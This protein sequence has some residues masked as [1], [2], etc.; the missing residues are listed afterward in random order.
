MKSDCC[1]CLPNL[2]PF[3]LCLICCLSSVSSNSG[4]CEVCP[5]P[6]TDC[7]CRHCLEDPDVYLFSDE[8]EDDEFTSSEEDEEML[9][10]LSDDTESDDE[11]EEGSEEF[12]DIDVVFAQDPVYRGELS[13]YPEL[14][15]PSKPDHIKEQF[16]T[17]E[18]RASY[19]DEVRDRRRECPV[20]TEKLGRFR[21]HERCVLSCGHIFCFDCINALIEVALHDEIDWFRCPMCRM[22]FRIDTVEEE[23]STKSESGEV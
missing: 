3:L 16:N 20:C 17:D 1:S 21:L 7:F 5:A 10:L 15:A 18:D 23:G 19:Y 14:C 2:F 12:S 9:E 4:V 6:Y 22:A 8:E 13:P 11:E